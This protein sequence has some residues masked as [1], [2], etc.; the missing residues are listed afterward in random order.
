[1]SPRPLAAV[2]TALCLLV[3]L[4]VAGPAAAQDGFCGRYIQTSSN[5]GLCLTC[6]LSVADNPQIEAYFV[7]ANTNW[8]A[9]LLWADGNP[10]AARGTGSWG[11]VEGPYNN[12][13]F[14]I[15]MWHE[16]EVLWV[17]MDHY[18]ANLPGVVEASFLCAD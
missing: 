4:P 10:G 8:T 15:D 17:Q 12:A 6:R 2:L 14:D 11:D 18:S 1:M 16:G 3:V 5:A 9:E 13:G 7:E